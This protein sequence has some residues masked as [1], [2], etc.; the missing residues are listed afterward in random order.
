MEKQQMDFCM[1]C[2]NPL[3]KNGQCMNCNFSLDTYKATF[4]CLPPGTLLTKRY[5]IG[6]VIGEGSFG[7]TYIGR[8][9]LLGIVIAI[10]EYFPLS[11]GSRNVRKEE[12]EI[13]V[14]QDNDKKGLEHFYE[15]AKLLSQFHMLDGIVS[16]RDFFYANKTAYIVMDYI[17]GITLKEHVK[18][19]GAVEGKEALTMMKPVI[20]SLHTIHQAEIIHRDISPDNILLTEQKKLVLVDFGSARAEDNRMTQSM[21]VTFKRG[22]TPEEQYLRR[23]K[24]GAWSDVYSLCATMYFMLTGI[25]PNEAIERM[26]Q[27][28]LVPLSK[29]SFVSLTQKQKN[30]IMQGVCV[31]PEERLQSMQELYDALY[32]EWEE[33]VPKKQFLQ[34]RQFKTA[35]FCI[36]ILVLCGIGWQI[37]QMAS[38][39]SKR[40]SNAAV[41]IVVNS[42]S[43]SAA[44]IEIQMQSFAGLTKEQAE[45]RFIALEDEHLSIVWKSEYND[46]VPK[47]IVITQNIPENT[48]YRSGSFHE[49][50]LTISKGQKKVVVPSVTD[51]SCQAAV[52]K[53]KKSHLSVCITWKNS[54]KSKNMVLKQSEKAGDKVKEGTKI[55]LTVSKGSVKKPAPTK[56]TEDNFDGTIP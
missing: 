10:K 15:E 24:L 3:N 52:E 36:L 8:D 34:T 43:P 37:N 47:G 51:I 12:Q 21:T 32:D 7:V 25:A 28:T 29:M 11:Y 5:L 35:V 42:S 45:N 46:R 18:K 6:R 16:V 56:K 40:A 54:K 50:V 19:N 14:Y 26:L 1:G 41:S 33:D 53:L 2:M 30:A 39:D 4:R 22:Y 9:L 55:K 27:D 44:P 31:K 48:S 20:R 23:G 49:L 17:K 13:Y 38:K